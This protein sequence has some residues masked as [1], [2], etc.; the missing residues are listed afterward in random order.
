MK[1][2]LVFILFG[3]LGTL[4]YSQVITGVVMDQETKEPIDFASVY[5]SGTFVG[6]TTDELGNFEM[7]ITKYA[8]R[9][10]SISVVGYFSVSISEFVPGEI[11]QVLLVRQLYD[12]EEVTVSTKSL[13]RRRRANMRIFRNEFIG[14]SVNARKCN[15]LNEEDITFNY[16]SDKDILKAKA[17]APILIQNLSLGYSISYHLER[18][19]YERKTKTML[20]TGSIIFNSDLA[21]DE[22]NMLL[23][24]RRR[25]NAY[26]GSCQHFFRALWANSL[27]ESEFSV[28]SYRSGE[29][30][31]YE[32][33]VYQDQQGRKYMRYH[34]DLVIDYH[35]NLSYISFIEGRVLFQ[36]DGYFDPTPIVWTGK[37]S[38]QRVADFL[39]YEYLLSE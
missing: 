27:E 11:H 1:R 2:I 32:D 25:A 38:L 13:A 17:K 5:F 21:S 28:S 14:L 36:E 7:D 10:L 31:S 16:G 8:S 3:L 30:L 34:E 4:T 12:I 29:A 6:T 37:M 22:D 9:P 26:L 33:L 19:K 20:F 15:I 23:Y 18:F 39:P 35:S 24:E